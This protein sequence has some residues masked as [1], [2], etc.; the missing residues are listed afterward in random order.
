MDKAF[1]SRFA[2]RPVRYFERV[3]STNDLARAWLREGA[4]TGA[5]VFADEQTRGRGRMGRSW[6]TPPGAALAV[7]VIL[8]PLAEH[9]HQI[10]MIGALAIYD[11][12]LEVGAVAVGIK[13][14]N[15]V[16]VSGRKVSGLLPEAEWDGDALL[17]VVLGMGVNVRVDFSG[18]ELEHKAISLEQ[19]ASRPL[20][21]LD[22]LSFLLNRVDYWYAQLGSTGVFETWKSRLLT[23]GQRVTIGQAHGLAESVDEQGAL[24]VRDDSGTIQ[25]VIAGDIAM[26]S[27][28]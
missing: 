6:Q 16:L 13:W 22:L 4:M 3:G 14:P 19:A 11:L 10:G 2:P 18:S 9:L 26:A 1:I 20:D 25:R 5:F 27:N 24:L 23:L 17:G 28:E 12:A 7:S 21:R 8:H 15:D